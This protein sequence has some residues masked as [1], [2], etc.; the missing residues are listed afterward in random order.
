VVQKIK[1][2]NRIVGKENKMIEWISAKISSFI[3]G[4][5]GGLSILSYIPPTTVKEA[6]MRGGVSVGFALMFAQ[7]ILLQIGLEVHPNELWM[8][9]L[10]IAFLCGFVGYS[11][12]N[13]VA[14]FLA[15]NQNKDIMEIGREIKNP[16]K[17]KRAKRK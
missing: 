15:K 5:L 8:Y 12:M 7:P 4:I 11:V 1:K 10:G 13:W 14:N 6:F 17:K 3:G 9:E 16:K 2:L